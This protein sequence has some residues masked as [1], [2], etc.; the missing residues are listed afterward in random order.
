MTLAL[1]LLQVADEPPPETPD[2]LAKSLLY[3]LREIRRLLNVTH[4]FTLNDFLSRNSEALIL[5][6]ANIFT[7]LVRDPQLSQTLSQDWTL[8][9]VD[10]RKIRG[11]VEPLIRSLSRNGAKLVQSVSQAETEAENRR[12]A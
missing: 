9:K 2:E 7:C 5:H 10:L 12:L 1:T 11:E 6:L 3:Y 8:T 4:L